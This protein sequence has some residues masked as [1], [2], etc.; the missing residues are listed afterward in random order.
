MMQEDEGMW[1]ELREDAEEMSRRAGALLLSYFRK[2]FVIE[3]KGAIDLVTDADKAAEELIVSLIEE[4]HPGDSILGEEGGSRSE[5]A[6]RR[7]VI[8]PLDGTINFAHGLGH[9]CVLVAAQVRSSEGVYETVASATF[10]PCAGEMFLAS[11]GGGATLNGRAIAVSSTR[12]LIDAVLAT[13]FGYDR[14]LRQPDNHAEFCRLSLLTR[15]VRRFGSAGLD[16]AHVACG[17]FDGYWEYWLNPWDM[18]AGLLLVEEAGG[19]T[20]KLDQCGVIPAD[21]EVLVT[22]GH[23][24]DALSSALLSARTVPANSRTGLGAFLPSEL[25]AKLAALDAAE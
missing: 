3:H 22:N 10:D 23:L 7:W 1:D 11:R 9:F 20:S 17:R 5:G 21:G 15:G 16:L 24:H 12:R 25:A 2:S 13:G 6:E 14:L 8:D 4:A 18:G 19:R